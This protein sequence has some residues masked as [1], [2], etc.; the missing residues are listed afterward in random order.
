[1]VQIDGFSKAELERAL[2]RGEMPFLQ[3]LLD[4]EHYR[5][6]PYYCGVPS[7]T[8]AVQ[9]ELFYGVPC[10]VPAFVF[11]DKV[12]RKIFRMFSGHDVQEIERRLAA[13]GQAL[14]EGGASYSNIYS[15]GA[16]EA[17]FCVSSLDWNTLW[18]D[19]NIFHFVFL[20]LT[21][22][23]TL[24]R[25]TVLAILELILATVDCIRAIVKGE[26]A[27]SEIHFIPVRTLISVV[28]R[29]LVTLSAKIDVARGLPIIHVNFLG[30]DEQSHHR[31]PASETAH[32]ALRGIDDSIAAIYKAAAR[33]TR[34]HYDVWVYSDHGQEKM[35]SYKGKYGRSVN[36]VV[37]ELYRRLKAQGVFVQ[38]TSG[39]AAAGEANFHRPHY[40]GGWFERLFFPSLGQI[41]DDEEDLLVIAMGN[42]GN[43]YYFEELT[44]EQRERF[45]RELV[46][47]AKVPLVLAVDGNN[48]IFAWNKNG[49]YTLPEQMKEI[50]GE[51]HPYLEEAAA[52][53]VKLCH[54]PNAGTFTI[55]GF[56]S[57][58]EYWGFPLEGGDHG[59]PGT[60][61]TDAFAI[62]PS[63]IDI[64]SEQRSYIRTRD[65]RHA[66]L[67]L[68]NRSEAEAKA[69]SS[70]PHSLASKATTVRLMTYNVHSCVGTDG[71]MSA[72]R[73]AR[74]IS[75]YEPDI[76]ALQELD[77]SRQRTAAED[78]PHIIAKHL[79]MLYHFHPSMQIEEEQFG[80]A[81]LSRFPMQL[82]KAGMLPAIFKG[83]LLEPRGVLWV[84]VDIGGTHL[85]FF[86]THLS[87]YHREA[88]KQAQA[89]LGKDWISH[90]QCTGPLVVCGDFNALP[91][92][93]VYRCV[94]KVLRDAQKAIPGQ[95]PKP[96]WF[97]HY[98]VGRIDHV[99]V[100]EG[101][102]VVKVQVADGQ[103]SRMVSDHLPLIVDIKVS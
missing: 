54:H 89:L 50:F 97:S 96:T 94:K 23:I 55:C 38:S 41:H 33:S 17:H 67:N 18:R 81:I 100:N 90:P 70:R 61:E 78:Q 52:D 25:M 1:M 20:L 4:K 39:K 35:I 87:L 37:L 34:R 63:G 75:R 95:R 76:I 32:W 22:F 46:D 45:A 88:L 85:Q 72:Q 68:L 65:L 93:P 57:S 5:L 86:T 83:S 48:K 14:L 10:A 3:R 21:N 19:I 91:H 60:N 51:H 62:I 59:G 79:E 13:Q 47:S 66:A 9:G 8:P 102:E 27:S 7:T 64:L 31:G 44:L 98:P 69:R 29:E 71:K 73:V 6:Y 30:Y 99:F 103:L 42:M 53:L 12:T 28:L 58:H 80:N 24:M 36:D 2:Q 15:G 43:I 11:R 101:I 82:K 16:K 77:L 40:C 74:V 56:S 26:N 49:R 84:D 92:S